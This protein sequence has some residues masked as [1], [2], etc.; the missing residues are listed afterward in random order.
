MTVYVKNGRN[1]IEFAISDLMNAMKKD[2][3]EWTT[4]GGMHPGELSETN[5]KMIA[6]FNDKISSKKGSKY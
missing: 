1:S 4:R 3:L 6:E 5:K 2:Y